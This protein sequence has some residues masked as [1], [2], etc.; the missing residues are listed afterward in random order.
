MQKEGLTNEGLDALL[1]AGISVSSR[2]QRREKDFFAGI[3]TEVLK[4]SVKLYP[5]V[6]TM[7]NLDINVGGTNHHL[8]QEYI[9]VEHNDTKDLDKQSKSFDETKDMFKNDTIIITSEQ[10][11]ALLEHLKKVV[12]ITIGRVLAD[13]LPEANF[14]K[15]MLDNHYDHPNQ[16]LKPK[17][18]VLFIQ[19]PL[20]LHEIVNAEMIQILDS[21][22]LDFLKLTRMGFC[23]I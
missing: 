4:S 15:A 22:Q 12:A 5:H 14:L 6:R 17:P 9:E 11:K 19:K 13:R 8:T 10:N 20:Y 23:Q 18:A 1:V 3:S 2:S 7:D 16:N 21:V